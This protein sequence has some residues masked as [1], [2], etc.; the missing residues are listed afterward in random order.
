MKKFPKEPDVMW[1]AFWLQSASI[2]MIYDPNWSGIENDI[3]ENFHV[4]KASTENT[5][6]IMTQSV[7]ET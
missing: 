4:G 5:L 6:S 3:M 7:W 1:S 2:G